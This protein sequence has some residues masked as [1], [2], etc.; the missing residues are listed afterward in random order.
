MKRPRD[1][2]L[3]LLLGAL[4]TVSPFAIDL[5]LASFADIAADLGTTPTR[6]ALTVSSYFVGL[7]IG[8]IVYG[9][10]LDRYGRKRPLTFGLGLFI[11]ASLACTAPR[12]LELLIVVRFLQALGG[13]SA[14]V[15]ATAM[16]RDFFPARAAPKVFS[17]LMLILGVSPLLAPTFGAVLAGAFGWR[18]IFY[19]LS[20]IVVFVLACVV[21][22]LPEGHEP[23][24]EVSLRPGPIAR[25][26][27][28]VYRNPRFRTYAVAGALSFSGL[29]AYVAGSPAIFLGTFGVSTRLYGAIFALLSIG[30]IGGSQLNLAL[31][32]RIS[33]E[34]IFRI[35][36]TIQ[37][38][39]SIA[40]FVVTRFGGPGLVGSVF[41]LLAI[42]ACVGLT[43][44]N[45]AAIA[46][47]PFGRNAGTAAALLGFLQIGAGAAAAAGLG[48]LPGSGLSSTAALLAFGSTCALT[49]LYLRE[50]SPQSNS[51]TK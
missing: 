38:V 15:A 23:D 4:C 49:M 3:I 6:L 26:Y 25:A 43:N 31:L 14:Q 8:Q 33:S 11:L 50:G 30:F 41:F 28:E 1:F 42:L 2:W 7:A 10:I 40:F 37:V 17:L 12:S 46:L 24:R 20:G 34:R 39:L 5:Y 16:V 18:A 35:A 9:P 21:F 22:L 32:R 36:L 44:P 51:A 29:F 27:A 48:I 45:A 19:A 47:A 13:A